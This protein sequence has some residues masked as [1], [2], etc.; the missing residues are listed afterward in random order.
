MSMVTPKNRKAEHNYVVGLFVIFLSL[1]LAFR[2]IAPLTEPY[3]RKP[4]TPQPTLSALANNEPSDVF[5]TFSNAQFE[6]SIAV[7]T[8]ISLKNKAQYHLLNYL[9]TE[10][11]ISG[12]DGWLFYKPQFLDGTCYRDQRLSFLGHRIQTFV[13]MARTVDIPVDI[14]MSP[15]KATVYPD[16]LHP[17]SRWLT[18]CHSANSTK[19]RT[20]MRARVPDLIDHYDAIIPHKGNDKL[21]YQTDTHWTEIGAT[22]ALRQLANR[23]LS[24]P[25]DDQ[26]SILDDFDIGETKKVTDLAAISLLGQPEKLI[27]LSDRSREHIKTSLLKIRKEVVFIHDSFYGTLQVFKFFPKARTFNR[28][29]KTMAR[30]L[31]SELKGN[32]AKRLVFNAVDRNFVSRM[33][34]Y[35]VSAPKVMD[36]VTARNGALAKQ[37]CPARAQQ[38]Q[39]PHSVQYR[40]MVP[41]Q[42]PNA[43]PRGRGKFTATTNDPILILQTKE[44]IRGQCLKISIEVAKADRV[45]VYLPPFHRTTDVRPWEEGRTLTYRLK[46]GVNDIHLVLPRNLRGHKLRID[47]INTKA[48]FGLTTLAVF[49]P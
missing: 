38:D 9:D 41:R 35:F 32:A 1:P 19:L 11:V 30:L 17:R 31:V 42:E 7:K 6:R 21:Y 12:T 16:R 3:G 18:A 24:V 49:R 20:I 22:Y 2:V 36:A 26:Q 13:S 40:N 8:A 33:E 45:K 44:P 14:S 34:H 46:P 29:N 37:I 15:D 25:E 4:F 48:P 23:M 10:Q 28:G 27:S 5:E 43:M 39:Y 47:P